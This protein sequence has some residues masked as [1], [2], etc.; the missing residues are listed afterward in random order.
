M[1][2]KINDFYFRPYF[3]CIVAGS[4]KAGKTELVRDMISQWE[5][6]VP[7]SH[8]SRVSIVYDTWQKSY[9]SIIDS[10][11]SNVLVETHLGLPLNNEELPLSS[12]CEM[13]QFR[14]HPS[15][16]MCR[17]GSNVV[18]DGVQIVIVDDVLQG[19]KH[20]SFL[21]SLFSI[22]SHHYKICAFLIT[23]QIFNNTDLNRSI[24]R[25]TEQVIICKSAVATST[26][27]ALQN[28]F[29]AGQAQYLN[30]A[31]RKIISRGGAYVWIDLS[32]SCNDS[33]RVKS[34]VLTTEVSPVFENILT[35]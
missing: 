25:N 6:V 2:N 17:I 35:P 10:L 16:P 8:I 11:P 12:E 29:F 32:S 34:G 15:R 3:T 22:F 28:Q 13:S 23:Q 7:N 26:L 19:Q 4:S 5:H 27:R 9:D 14:D 21:T 1:F 31:Y 20:N 18:D 30:S 24:V 33:R